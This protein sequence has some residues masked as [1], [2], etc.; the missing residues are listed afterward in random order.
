MKFFLILLFISWLH[1]ASSQQIYTPRSVSLIHKD[2]CFW[3]YSIERIGTA[4]DSMHY[5]CIRTSLVEEDSTGN[6]VGKPKIR[7]AKIDCQFID[8]GK[9]RRVEFISNAGG[10]W[11]ADFAIHS[12]EPLPIEI[13]AVYN[14]QKRIMK[15]T[16]NKG[17]FPG[18]PD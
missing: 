10:E 8:R 18:E 9:L 16:L 6:P 11:V 7:G 2:K 13:I 12:D 15:D 3:S 17:V 1:E 4:H 14:K 5:Y